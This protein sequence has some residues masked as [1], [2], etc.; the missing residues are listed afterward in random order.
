MALGQRGFAQDRAKELNIL[1]WEGYNS[2][3]VLDPFRTEKGRDGQGGVADQ[4]SDDDQPAA[5]R[6][7]QRLGS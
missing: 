2:A 3:Q 4:R 6:R 7:D 1:C 5:R